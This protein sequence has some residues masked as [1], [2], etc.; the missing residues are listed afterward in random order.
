M[1]HTKPSA[2]V[3]VSMDGHRDGLIGTQRERRHTP[4]KEHRGPI[5]CLNNA[6]SSMVWPDGHEVLFHVFKHS[7]SAATLAMAGRSGGAHRL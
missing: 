3:F 5:V 1:T 2:V 7:F 4:A 6:V